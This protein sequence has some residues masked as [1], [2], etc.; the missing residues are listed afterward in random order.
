MKGREDRRRTNQRETADQQT[1]E[2][3]GTDMSHHILGIA[4]V[5]VECMTGRPQLPHFV[6]EMTPAF[7]PMT[8]M[9]A[10]FLIVFRCFVDVFGDREILSDSNSDFA[11]TYS[12]VF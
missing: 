1:F 12:L 4:M 6:P 7:P 11:H 5:M 10:I 8:P 3:M 2:V 9:P